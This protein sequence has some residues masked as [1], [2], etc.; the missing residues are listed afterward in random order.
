MV[1][2]TS[3]ACTAS[4]V[5][6]SGVAVVMSMPS[7]AMAATAVGLSCSAGSD[8]AE[9]TSM[10][11][12][13]NSRRY[14][15]AIWE[16]PAL[17]T[18]TTNTEGWSAGAGC[19]ECFWVVIALSFRGGEFGQQG[20]HARVDV[21]A[22]QAHRLDPVDA[23]L[24]GFSGGPGVDDADYGLDRFDPGLPAQD[25]DPIDAALHARIDGS[26]CF[27]RHVSPELGDDLSRQVVDGIPGLGIGG[28]HF[29]ADVGFLGVV[30]HQG[31]SH[32]GFATVFH[33][34]K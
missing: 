10:R 21:V 16:R 25:H 1:M 13:L 31:R 5:R 26:G 12:W 33:A 15:A 32:L 14:P 9:R 34:D 18:H 2:T 19:W 17:W 4:G 7:S 11:S 20:T 28:V 6:M 27:D 8:P 30:A 22:D 24:G 3:E 29:H 23:A